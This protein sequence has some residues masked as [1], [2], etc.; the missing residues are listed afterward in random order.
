MFTCN[1]HHIPISVPGSLLTIGAAIQ[2]Q[3]RYTP[4]GVVHPAQ[5][6]LF[7][8]HISHGAANNEVVRLLAM[9]DGE[10]VEAA[11][12]ASAAGVVMT[13][14]GRGSLRLVCGLDGRIG[15]TLSGIGLRLERSTARPFDHVTVRD[16]QS[17][18][19]NAP[20]CNG[21][22]LLR[23]QHGSLNCDAPW[24]RVRSARFA[25]DILPDA[26]GHGIADLVSW[27]HCDNEPP[28]I[29]PDTLAT[30][31]TAAFSAWQ[32]PFPATH[33][34]WQP[35]VEL[36][37]WLL[38][39]NQ[40]GP[41]GALKRR[42]TYQSQYKM[43]NFWTWDCCFNALGLA[44]IHPDRAWEEFVGAF[45][46]Q[47]DN[48]GLPCSFNDG[49]AHWNHAKPPIHGWTLSHLRALGV[50]DRSRCQA[51]LDPLARWTD[52]WLSHLGWSDS[53]IPVY[54]HG[55]DSGW[56]NA[57]CFDVPPPF[58]APDLPAFLALQLREQAAIARELGDPRAADWEQQASALV[59]A[60]L[61]HC[62]QDNRFVAR[63][64]DG[65]IC[66]GD[67]LLCCLP[68]VL[69]EHLPAPQR[70]AIID[71]LSRENDFLTPHGLA[72]EA[73]ASPYRAP[74]GYWRGSIWAPPVILLCDGLRRAGATE[75]ARR[76]AARFCNT[77]TR[78][79][80]SENFDPETAAPL[81]DPTY[82]W[83]A[84]SML[85]LLQLFPGLNPDEA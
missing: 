2:P 58:V 57:S 62:W 16:A 17:V 18:V 36:A 30:D 28:H 12:E 49:Q 31:S 63:S 39:S 20:S 84:S 80:F 19:I 41:T 45:D 77:C 79:G 82:T 38:W 52:W 73:L 1:P 64:L 14:P 55:N 32:A 33:P 8:R 6:G 59:E 10:A 23:C 35:A 74:D 66:P 61:R 25:L 7:V 3:H 13:V 78:S 21:S 81:R 47:A 5:P 72:T 56:D 40:V 51:I 27:R 11:A 75:L 67:S 48:G 76:I 60:L 85:A 9:V 54:T 69:G 29:D 37:A 65:T 53:G 24:Q 22:W 43:T 46:H 83:T 4:P 44:P 15:M 34:Q 50:A 68:M 70:Q 71:R 42:V 26:S